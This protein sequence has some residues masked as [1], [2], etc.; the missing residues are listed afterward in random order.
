MPARPPGWK[1]CITICSHSAARAGIRTSDACRHQDI[2]RSTAAA[3]DFLGES[4]P[5]HSPFLPHLRVFVDH[6]E[7]S[8]LPVHHAAG[9]VAAP[10]APPPVH[11][12]LPVCTEGGGWGARGRMANGGWGAKG[13]RRNKPRN[14]PTPPPPPSP[15]L[16]SKHSEGEERTTA[17]TMRAPPSPS[18]PSSSAYTAT[19]LTCRT[20][21]Q[22]RGMR[23]CCCCCCWGSC[24][25]CDSGCCSC[26]EPCCCC[27]EAP[28]GEGDGAPAAPPAAAA[29]PKPSKSPECAAGREGERRR[30]RQRR[31][32]EGSASS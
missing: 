16:T 22:A 18:G 5:P 3:A 28:P 2:R 25:C 32:K 12:H 10:A 19:P 8:L 1:F 13:E 26:R 30:R 4:R 20:D 21:C 9:E 31:R 23:C 7:H 17:D 14:H 29:A 15:A 27:C 11:Q 6:L 24:C